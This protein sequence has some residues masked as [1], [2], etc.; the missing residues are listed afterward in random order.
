MTKIRL[1]PDNTWYQWYDW[2]ISH[3]LEFMKKSESD[4]KPEIVRLF[5]SNTDNNTPTDYKPKKKKKKYIH[6]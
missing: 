5:Q 2:S 6:I 3:I 1:I 4:A